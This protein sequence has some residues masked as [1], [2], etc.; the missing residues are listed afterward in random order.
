[1]FIINN[2]KI[3]LGIAGFI[4][5]LSISFVVFLGLN[6]GIEFTGGS[7]LEVS[8]EEKTPSFN[9]V[10]AII[11]SVDSER[12]FVLQEVGNNGYLIRTRGLNEE[13]RLDLINTLSF[14]DFEAQEERFSSIGPSMGTDLANKAFAAIFLVVISI[15]LFI[16]YVFR[17]VSKP[18]SSWKYGITAIMALIFDVL[19]PVGIFAVLGHFFGAEIDILFVTAI[20]AILGF[21]VNDTIVV[22]DR[23]REN[24]R[25]NEEY[26]MKKSFSQTVGESLQQTYVRSINTSLTTLF[27]LAAL[28]FVGPTVTQFFALVLMVGVVSGTYS[29]L[30]LA[31]PL[32]VTIEDR[33]RAKEE[34]K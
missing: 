11:E 7:I 22:F 28:F 5:F 4:V 15:I 27:V 21:S 34:V 33:Q 30:F 1:M 32:L 24:L 19:V 26:Q 18:V 29:S 31:S 14:N 13:E 3:F 6:F 25:I 10:H 8:Y 20:L 12:G 2:K 17:K 9:E 23:I 16:A